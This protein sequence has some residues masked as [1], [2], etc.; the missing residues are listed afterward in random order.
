MN[1]DLVFSTATIEEWFC[2]FATSPWVFRDSN[3]QI[4][5]ALRF[6]PSGLFK[7]LINTF[8]LSIWLFL[9]MSILLI[10]LALYMNQITYY[11]MDKKIFK[12]NYNFIEILILI[13]SYLINTSTKVNNLILSIWTY[14]S[15]I[16]ICCINGNILCSLVKQDM[17]TINTFQELIDYNYS[18]IGSQSTF[19][20]EFNMTRPGY[21][22]FNEL[23]NKT[24]FVNDY[25]V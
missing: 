2:S 13:C 7:Q 5:S 4:L 6:Y 22:L 10:S 12:R 24:N 23:K 3:I 18:I 17:T 16:F 8:S 20:R 9:L 11:L 15:I 14:V 1:V 25:F 19:Y 21:E